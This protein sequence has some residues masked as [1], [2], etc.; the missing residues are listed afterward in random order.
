MRFD[1]MLRSNIPNLDECI[2]AGRYQEACVLFI[3]SAI[4]VGMYSVAICV[5]IHG[6]ILIAGV[7]VMKTCNLVLVSS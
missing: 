5:A 3:V 2:F 6:R 4:S 7:K 1:T